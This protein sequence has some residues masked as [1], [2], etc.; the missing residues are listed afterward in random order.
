MNIRKMT[1]IYI[2]LSFLAYI[3]EHLSLSLF[4]SLSLC[5]LSLVT[6]FIINYVKSLRWMERGTE[7][8]M[9]WPTKV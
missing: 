4:V 7:D 3:D 6:E 8:D 2:S 5:S 1:D 9:H